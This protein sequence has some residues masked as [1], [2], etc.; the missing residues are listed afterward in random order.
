MLLSPIYH[1]PTKIDVDVYICIN[2]NNNPQSYIPNDKRYVLKRSCISSVERQKGLTT[3]HFHAQLDP[4]A[5]KLMIC[6]LVLFT[7]IQLSKLRV[8]RMH[9]YLRSG[10]RHLRRLITCLGYDYRKGIYVLC[11]R[12]CTPNS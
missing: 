4:F 9:K 3:I 6:T 8:R 5:A 11:K 12:D 2:N 10:I 1:C 7:I